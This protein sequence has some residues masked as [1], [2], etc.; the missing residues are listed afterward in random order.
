MYSIGLT[1]NIASGK[2]TVTQH[3]ADLGVGVINADTIARELTAVG[4]PALQ[5]ITEYFGAD[6]ITESGEL[7]RAALRKRIFN[8]PRER[9]WL[10][11]LLHPLIRS[12][13]GERLAII[14]SHPY[15][16]IEI[17]LLTSTEGYPYLD[18]VLVVLA[19][20]HK[21]IERLMKRDNTTRSQA[22]NILHTQPPDEERLRLADDVLFNNN[23]LETLYKTV[24][25]LHQKYLQAAAKKS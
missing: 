10:E 13:I 4:Q 7:N 2:S 16:V 23:G 14:G 25:K 3:F 15:C 20:K 1:G 5:V 18:R 22:L 8:Y 12:A 11:A 24:D 17:P 21:Q 9:L 19:D 6:I